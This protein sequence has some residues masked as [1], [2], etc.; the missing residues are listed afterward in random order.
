MPIDTSWLLE[1]R[2]M[3]IEM[4]GD[5]SLDDM[6]QGTLYSLD[7]LNKTN[8]QI[9]QIIDLSQ[10]KSLPNNIAE[11][12]KIAQPA[13]EHEMMGWVIVYGV[14]N[15]LIKFIATMTGHIS[16]TQLKIV[17]SQAEAIDVLKRI[18]VLLADDFNI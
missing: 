13:N 18:E 1:D 14:Q 15:K 6:R 16:K 4:S 5:L 2:V 9:H 12:A 11:F 8:H 10:V 17:D 7:A 3:L